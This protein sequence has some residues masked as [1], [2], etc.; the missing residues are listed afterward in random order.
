MAYNLPLGLHQLNKY[1]NMFSGSLRNLF[2]NLF[3]NLLSDLFS[4]TTRNHPGPGRNNSPTNYRRADSAVKAAC[5]AA[6][7]SRASWPGA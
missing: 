2:S 3:S 6:R 5:S 4:D 1:L 7:R